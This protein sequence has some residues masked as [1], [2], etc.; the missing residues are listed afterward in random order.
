MSD[1]H[2]S[3]YS[4]TDTRMEPRPASASEIELRQLMLP[5]H[6]NPFGNVHGAW[7]MKLI[8]EAGGVAAMRHC[9]SR[10]ATKLVDQMTFDGPVHVGDL[11]HVRSR[12]TWTGRTSLETMVTV[13]S[14]KV[15]TGE[16][17]GTNS[18]FLVFVALDTH[19][20][21]RAVPP[22]LLESDEDQAE[23]DAAERRRAHRLSR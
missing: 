21:P 13:E 11:V 19:G 23:W 16:L 20:L 1:D 15:L 6:A 2:E 5:E 14:E 4:K 18:A 3:S 12:V 8:D 9:R 7:I 17:R 22:L 10:V